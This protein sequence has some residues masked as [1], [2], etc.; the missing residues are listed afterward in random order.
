MSI[1]TRPIGQWPGFE[2]P[3][4]KRRRSQF[5]TSFSAIMKLLEREL[6]YLGAKNSVIEIDCRPQDFRLDGGLRANAR[7][8][9]PRVVVSCDTK[10]G[11]MR[12]PCDTFTKH[13]DNLYAIALTLEKLRAIDRYGVTVKGEQY[14]GF[15]AIPAATG[16]TTRVDAAWTTL[17]READWDLDGLALGADERTR[18]TLDNMFRDAAKRAHPDAGGSDERMAAVNRARETI[19]SSLAGD[20]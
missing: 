1:E 8:Q 12:L 2:T 4:H 16:I 18:S 13:E 3:E 7:P 9:G 15:T 19:L 6:W 14:T 11:A 17:E 20:S 10:H 5:A